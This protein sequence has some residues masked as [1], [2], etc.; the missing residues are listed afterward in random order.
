MRR[1]CRER[2]RGGQGFRAP[3]LI[4]NM[5]PLSL[6]SRINTARKS[7][8]VR[9]GE[10]T[11][12]RRV[13]TRA[14]SPKRV[15]P[16]SPLSYLSPRP[17]PC[18]P[19]FCLSFTFAALSFQPCLPSTTRSPSPH[20]S[21]SLIHQILIDPLPPF[22]PLPC[23]LAQTTTAP[24]Q[25]SDS[26][27]RRHPSCH[28]AAPLLLGLLLLDVDRLGVRAVLLLLLLRILLVCDTKHQGEHQ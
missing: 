22:L 4:L 14:T 1:Y 17:E 24:Q 21:F 26:Q 7:E 20:T 16:P 11:K 5:I 2:T 12:G 18:E 27:T 8:D 10:G 25:R 28:P 9:E 19:T 3:S 15:R 13:E 6:S 23:C